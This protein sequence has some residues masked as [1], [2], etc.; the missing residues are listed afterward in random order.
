MSTE[1]IKLFSIGSLGN[2]TENNYK[3]AVDK[4]T[5]TRDWFDPILYTPE[6]K[7]ANSLGLFIYNTDEC[8]IEWDGTKGPSGVK[9][10]SPILESL[11]EE[12]YFPNVNSEMGYGIAT[13]SCPLRIELPKDTTYLLTAP[14][15][16]FLP[17]I[18]VLSRVIK[19]N[20]FTTRI[21]L[22]LRLQIPNIRVRIAVGTPLAMLV[23]IVDPKIM[24]D[25]NIEFTKEL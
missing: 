15:N 16:V 22:H 1:P 24:R 12:G 9:V 11:P 25:Q 5:E 19:A 13:V 23:P 17:N 18:L 3:E 10:Y 7:E 21:K 8:E 14:T 20:E 2:I 4:P 6:V